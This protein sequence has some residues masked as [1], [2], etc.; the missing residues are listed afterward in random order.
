M[1]NKKLEIHFLETSISLTK[2]VKIDEKWC[3]GA[4]LRCPQSL[5]NFLD[6]LKRL[7][8]IEK[9]EKTYVIPDPVYKRAILKL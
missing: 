4:K 3:F 2:I 6:K 7:Y 8:L 1:N 9:I 5:L